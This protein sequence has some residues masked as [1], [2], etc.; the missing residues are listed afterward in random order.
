MYRVSPQLF[1]TSEHIMSDNDSTSSSF[2]GG[3]AGSCVGFLLVREGAGDV[4]GLWGLGSSVGCAGVPLCEGEPS[5]RCC[6]EPPSCDAREEVVPVFAPV[7]RFSDKRFSSVPRSVLPSSSSERSPDSRSRLSMRPRRF[8]SPS[9]Y[10]ALDFHVSSVRQQGGFRLT[11]PL[12][13]WRF[14]STWVKTHSVL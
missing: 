12:G 10:L 2:L 3:G 4:T 13:G 6:V 14:F 5:S 9:M 7:A 8:S 1:V 11:H